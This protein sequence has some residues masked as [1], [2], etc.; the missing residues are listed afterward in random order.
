MRIEPSF[1]KII[2]E[3]RPQFERIAEGHGAVRFI[4]ECEHALGLLQRYDA[5]GAVAR[6]NPDSLKVA[7]TDVAEVGLTLSPVAQHAHLVPRKG[8]VCLD[9]GYRGFLHLGEQAGVISDAKPVLVYEKDHFKYL[10]VNQPP[11]H[12]FDP[13]APLSER[14]LF[15]G[16]YCLAKK[17]GGGHLVDFMPMRDILWIRDRTESF[18]AFQR[19]KSKL[20][21]WET[22]FEQMALKTI[23]RR[24]WKTWPRG[25][26]PQRLDRAIAISNEHDGILLP[27]AHGGGAA[28]SNAI[29]KVR[30]MLRAQGRDEK[31]YVSYL[32]EIH[33]RTIGS[34][35]QLSE[36]ELDHAF[37]TLKALSPLKT[38]GV[39]T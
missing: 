2:V 38:Q 25:K 13:F 37:I 6:R 4:Q 20:C 17:P 33:R 15:R 21:A 28:P 10:G 14:G 3:V 34:L 11:E 24:A 18:M 23:V 27:A 26:R 31:K 19:D 35:D 12:D 30:A 16:G 32:G 22:D 36:S 5:L 9:I 29:E 1:A 8:A 7:I 39:G